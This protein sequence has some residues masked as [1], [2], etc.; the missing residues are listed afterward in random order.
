[1][2]R[3]SFYD[4]L[5]DL[6]DLAYYDPFKHYFDPSSDIGREYLKILRL[7][8]LAQHLRSLVMSYPPPPPR[9]YTAVLSDLFAPVRRT[10][11]RPQKQQ[12]CHVFP[13][14]HHHGLYRAIASVLREQKVLSEKNVQKPTPQKEISKSDKTSKHL[15]KKTEPVLKWAKKLRRK[16]RQRKQRK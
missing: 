1:M 6:A 15:W 7:K 8:A 16:L 13:F 3:L 9:M 11:L 10:F 4:L 2:E 12:S 5:D 14:S